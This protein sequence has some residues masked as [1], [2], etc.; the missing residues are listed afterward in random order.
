MSYPASRSNL[1]HLRGGGVSFLLEL[2]DPMP[3]IL[4]WGADLGELSERELR[5]LVS[6]AVPAVT[7]NSTDAPRFFSVLPTEAEAW[8][9]TPGFEGRLRASGAPYFRFAL[10]NVSSSEASV[11]FTVVDHEAQISVTM[12]YAIDATSGILTTDSSVQRIGVRAEPDDIFDLGQ[13]TLMLPLPDRA[14]EIVDF[15][16]KWS[17]ERSPQRSQLQFG[18]HLRESRRGRSSLDSPYLLMAGTKSFGFRTGEVWGVH[19]GWSGNQRYLVEQLPESAGVHRSAIG[20]GELLLPGEITLVAGQR[21]DAPTVYFAWSD[22]GMDGIA[23]QFHTMLRARPSHPKSPRPLVMN[24]WE[25]V[26]FDHDLET[27]LRL[28]DAGAAVGVERMVLDDGWFLGRRGD[29]TG[30][31]DWFVDPEVW[32]HGLTP[33]VERI[34]QHGM[35]FGLWFEP[36]MVNLTSRLARENPEW[37]LAPLAGAGPSIRHQHVLNIAHPDAWSFLFERIDGLVSEYKIDYIK[38]DH[39]RELHEAGRREAGG[40]AGVHT[41]T[42]ALYRLLDALKAKHPKLEIESCASGG[43][44]V[45][46]G[47]LE[48]TDRVW[49]SDCNDPVE[50]QLIQ[51]W[52]GQLIPPELVGTHV[53]A[54]ESHTTRRVT[55]F[56]FRLITALFGHAGIELDLTASDEQE[57]ATLTAWTALYREMRGLLHSGRVVRAD[58]A[59]E[60][61]FFHGVVAWDANEA[62][63]TWARL[64]TSVPTQAGRIVFPGLADDVLYSIRVREELGAPVLHEGEPQWFALARSGE[65]VM[66]GSTLA[67]VGLSMPTLQAQ[68]AMLLHLTTA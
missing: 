5:S 25:A 15:T 33:F 50:R 31:G 46:L 27:L 60:E 23:G 54:A 44:R 28:A 53:G 21:Y 4:H 67:K 58:T 16:G 65:L 19:V 42:E 34:R 32:P 40:R 12:A 64:G 45:D 29:N 63:F 68:Q 14:V 56:P 3:R 2:A 7:H 43:G 48:R 13:V 6:T 20:G 37:V 57:L 8:S 30:L 24:T 51:R 59:D 35:Q 26:Y 22:Q 9:G 41:Q 10:E 18:T 36:E 11:E 1:A 39:N 52:T 47:V 61:S 66:S 55:S 49:A 17:R 38:W 62:L